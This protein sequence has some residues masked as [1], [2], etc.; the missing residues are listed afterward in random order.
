MLSQLEDVWAGRSIFT[1]TDHMCMYIYI[2]I[3]LFPALSFSL[4]P[5][6]LEAE[7]TILL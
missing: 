6:N 5:S 2:Y 1:S 3:K 4:D 7:G